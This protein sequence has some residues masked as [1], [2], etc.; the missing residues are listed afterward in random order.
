MRNVPPRFSQ[1]MFA[2]TVTLMSCPVISTD[3]DCGPLPPSPTPITLMP[4]LWMVTGKFSSPL[5]L[6]YIVRGDKSFPMCSHVIVHS[7]V[8]CA[9]VHV[10]VIEVLFSVCNNLL[11]S[12]THKRFLVFYAERWNFR[13]TPLFKSD[14][15]SECTYPVAVVMCWMLNAWS[16]WTTAAGE[17]HFDWSPFSCCITVV[18]SLWKIGLPRK[19]ARVLYCQVSVLFNRLCV[20]ILF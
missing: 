18:L 19:F 2:G 13:G 20:W 9:C 6:L 16:V 11:W 15:K 1:T 3:H 10:C 17:V 7:S 4:Y 8:M 5:I 14:N 12:Q